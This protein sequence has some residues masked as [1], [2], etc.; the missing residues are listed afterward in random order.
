MSVGIHNNSQ[1]LHLGSNFVLNEDTQETK[2]QSLELE[3]KTKYL[4][5]NMLSY[6]DWKALS[7]LF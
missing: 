7:N 3:K 5:I 2:Q 4:W 1:K 6:L